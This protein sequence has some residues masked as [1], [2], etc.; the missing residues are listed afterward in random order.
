[1]GYSKL[2]YEEYLYHPEVYGIH[3]PKWSTELSEMGYRSICAIDFYDDIFGEDLEEE[4]MPDDY[5]K[6]EYGGIAIETVKRLDENGNI[7]LDK[8]GKIQYVGKRITVTK[9]NQS[10]YNLIDQSDNFCIIAPISYA[11]RTRTNENARY[12]YAFCIEV[13]DI[14]PNGGLNEL[15]YSWNRDLQPLPK[16]TYITCSGNG[17]HLYY[18]FER[19]IPLWRNVFETF[20]EAK[21]YFTPRLW[22]KYI[23]NSYDKIQYGSVNQPFRCVGSRTKENGYVL[24]FE[25][26]SKI[27]IEYLN[28]FLPMD[29]QLDSFYKSSC[30]LEQAKKLYPDWYK[31]RIEKGEERG[32]WNRHKPIYYNWK[33]KI[34]SGAVVGARYNCLEN[35]CSLAVQCNIAPEEVE[36]DCREVAE[37]FEKLTIEEK[38]H[39]TS[40]DV[41]CALK[42]YYSATGQAYRRRI[43][44]ISRKTKI[45]LIPNARK[46]QKQEWHLEDCREKKKR[47]KQRGQE[48]KNTEGRPKGSGTKEKMVKEYK[49]ANPKAN[50]TEVARALGISRPTVYKYWES[51]V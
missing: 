4:R 24:A 2:N 35:L 50:I 26:G 27:T 44:Y 42:T 18:V 6:G 32:H 49:A 45:T 5:K 15:F 17:L 25:I 9:G 22:T 23:T 46:G 28:K 16:P 1:M 48:F 39:F 8:K 38:N 13:D 20:T 37:Y 30:S 14:N 41:I 34:L 36:K 40:Y 7:L 31:K 12:M 51:E 33:E 10:L 11:G 19:P 47:M 3:L 29:K 21:K 43:D